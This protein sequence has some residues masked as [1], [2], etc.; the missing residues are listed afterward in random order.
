MRLGLLA[1]ICCVVACSSDPTP[2]VG[3]DAGVPA[4]S[5]R[6][7]SVVH[8]D[9]VVD[10]GVNPDPA[11]GGDAA[12][13]EDVPDLMDSGMANTI[14]ELSD[15]FETAPLD[16]SWTFFRDDVA[17]VLVENG[18]MSI[19]MTR[20]Q[21]WFNANT[22]SFLYKLVTGDFKVTSRVRARKSSDPNAPPTHTIHL[23]G[24]MARDPNSAQENY[25]FIVVGVDPQD[26]SVE[27]K[28][29]V[30]SASDYVGP[31]W[32]STEA[33]LRL[34]RVGA[35]FRLYKRELGA[36]VWTLAMTYER[37]D[38]PDTLQVGGNA[39]AG[40]MNGMFDLRVFFDEITFAPASGEGDCSAD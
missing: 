9:A 3:N 13:G 15:D 39:Y 27:T 7:A 6:D 29:T 26:V 37:P 17:D 1:V 11:D 8:P 33:E 24:V 31:P 21:L 5:G 10:L 22:S 25:V 18:S 4:D 19:T 40:A 23:G 16:P 34:C 36:G 35:T 32:S 14:A 30:N 2:S 20:P 28:S 12:V 38:L